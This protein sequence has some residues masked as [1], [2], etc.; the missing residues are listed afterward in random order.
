MANDNSNGGKRLASA[1]ARA[2]RGAAL[3]GLHGAAVGI[4]REF[5][6]EIFKTLGIILIT[7]I[8]IPI[9]IFTALPNILFGFESS[10]KSEITEF[11]SLANVLNTEYGEVDGYAE[12]E[13]DGLLESILEQ[14]GSNEEIVYD[15]VETTRDLTNLNESWFI[16]ITSVANNQDLFTIDSS[17]IKNMV[18]LKIDSKWEIVEKVIDE[19]ED[20]STIQLLKIEVYD[21]TPEALMDKLDFTDEQRNWARVLYSTLVQEQNLTPADGDIYY[22][23]DYGNIV[24]TDAAVDVVYYNQSDSRWGGKPYG[25]TRTIAAAGCGPTALAM[26]V[27]T[28][29]DSSVTPEDVATWGAGYYV[30]DQGSSR[31]LIT[32]GGA[33]YGLTVTGL[34]MDA[35]KV[36]DA[37]GRGNLVIAIMVKGHFTKSG[38]F[39]LLR[40]ITSDGNILVADPGSVTR[41]NQEWSLRLIANE[42][43]R[44][45]YAGGPFWELSA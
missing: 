15:D 21:I 14:L 24:F 22:G 23:T 33:H 20:E 10:T 19:D 36:A 16:A 12:T 28:L 17:T 25:K 45:N 5:A 9:L 29:A 26:A 8:V 11:T 30:Q 2:A 4:A 7:L 13:A 27:A 1:M 38:H 40:G 18:S 41:S 44:S 32:E 31:T 3:G 34:G 42:V 35:Q 43:G 6:P 39:I 37:L